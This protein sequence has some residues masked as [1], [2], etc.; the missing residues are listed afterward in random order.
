MT[1]IAEKYAARWMPNGE[2]SLADLIQAAVDEAERLLLTG[3]RA[4]LATLREKVA[5]ADELRKDAERYRWLRMKGAH[6]DAVDKVHMFG[7]KLDRAT[8]AA[9]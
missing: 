2:V 4:E 5:E 3:A 8:H 9:M 1:S 7:P 6:S